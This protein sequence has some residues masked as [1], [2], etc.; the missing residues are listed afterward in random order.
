MLCAKFACRRSTMGHIP[1]DLISLTVFCLSLA[2]GGPVSADEIDEL[3]KAGSELV[4]AYCYRCHGLKYNGSAELNVMDRTSLLN[5]NSEYVVA[6]EVDESYL[7]QRIDEG[8]MPP[9]QEDQPTAAEKAII[10]RW[11]DAGAPFPKR[12]KRPFLRQEDVLESILT[13]LQST[14]SVDRTYVRYF[15]LTHLFN[16]SENVSKFNLKMFRA[17][18]SKAVNSLS[19]QPEIVV[20]QYIDDDQ[21]IARIDLRDL[22]WDER[23][24]WSEVLKA[25]P[26]GLEFSGVADRKLA[27]TQREVES[28]SGTPLPYVRADWLTVTA[29]RPP[30][31]HTLLDIPKTARELER[32]LNV[33]PESDFRR[34]R[35]RRA[36]FAESG[37]STGNRLVDRH[38]ASYGYYWKSYDFAP[39]RTR[40]NLFKFPLG[41]SIDNHPFPLLAFQHDGGEMIFALPNRLQG[42][43]L[44][45]AV[46]NRIDEGPIQVVRDLKESSGSPVVVNGISC[47]HCHQHGMIKFKDTVR[48]GATVFG[49][50]REKVQ[51]LFVEPA[52]MRAA[53]KRDEE[54]FLQALDLAIGTF[55]KVGEDRN[56]SIKDFPEPII[57]MAHFYQRGLGLPEVACELGIEDPSELRSAIMFNGR[58]KRLGLLPLVNGGRVKRSEW[59]SRANVI[60]PFQMSSRL[61]DRGTP[62]LP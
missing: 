52:D 27:E 19:W 11:I 56:K 49:T 23:N 29:T 3:A 53:V 46:G 31:Y 51:D 1:L 57:S 17:A 42:Y 25:Y 5:E 60:S 33:D 50:A 6:G 21:T 32:E 16:N 61:L 2:T 34:N 39:D 35:V 43:M 45:D 24:L 58:L 10:K 54:Q 9:R 15:T 38:S 41:P 30:L 14:R 37:V 44:I 62:L 22:G 40:G 20:P 4:N 36:G 59:E 8:E 28:L 55:L 47:M 7:W 26:Y 18:F 12:V 13:D 48:D